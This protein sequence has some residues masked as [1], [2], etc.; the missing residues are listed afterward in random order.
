MLVDVVPEFLLF[1]LVKSPSCG[2]KFPNQHWWKD[3]GNPSRNC[4][5]LQKRELQKKQRLLLLEGMRQEK[6]TKKHFHSSALPSKPQQKVADKIR[7]ATLQDQFLICGWSPSY[8]TQ[9]STPCV[10]QQMSGPSGP[11][12]PHIPTPEIPPWLTLDT[13]P[14]LR[15]PGHDLP[16]FHSKFPPNISGQFPYPQPSFQQSSASLL[17]ATQSRKTRP[18]A[19]VFC[20]TASG[21]FTTPGIVTVAI[22]RV[23]TWPNLATSYIDMEKIVF[24]MV[25]LNKHLNS[26]VFF[27][28]DIGQ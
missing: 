19:S 2:G 13:Q 8:Q 15:F 25:P 9:N 16:I 5:S 14:E 6:K 18:R 12:S 22:Q 21:S 27:H 11:N 28:F 26:L 4:L 7:Q 10:P 3:R 17:H 23:G 20:S 1:L 24:N